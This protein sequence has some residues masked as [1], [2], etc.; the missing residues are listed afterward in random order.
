[1]VYE[2]DLNKAIKQASVFNANGNDDIKQIKSVPERQIL[3]VFLSFVVL[4]FYTDTNK[5]W[6]HR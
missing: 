4:G 6:V 3:H 5:P 1:M 2:L